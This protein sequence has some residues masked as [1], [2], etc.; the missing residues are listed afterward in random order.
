MTKKISNFEALDQEI[1]DYGLYNLD[2]EI[3][4]WIHTFLDNS[5]TELFRIENNFANINKQF[6]KKYFLDLTD[7]ALDNIK[8]TAIN[9]QLNLLENKIINLSLE[10]EIIKKETNQQ[11]VKREAKNRIKDLKN[12]EKFIAEHRE[13]S[14]IYLNKVRKYDQELNHFQNTV[15]GNAIWINDYAVPTDIDNIKEAKKRKRSLI[16]NNEELQEFNTLLWQIDILQTDQAEKDAL[17]QRLE[18]VQDGSIDP[19]SDPYIFQYYEDYRNIVCTYPYLDE[20]IDYENNSLNNW[21]RNANIVVYQNGRNNNTNNNTNNNSISGNTRHIPKYNTFGEAVRQNW[22]EGWYDH[23]MNQTNITPKQ[24][25]FRKWAATVGGYAAIAIIGFSRVKNVW[26]LI[27]NKDGERTDKKIR[28]KVLWLPILAFWVN[29]ATGRPIRDINGVIKDIRNKFGD[30]NESNYDGNIDDDTDTERLTY[31]HGFPKVAKYFS[32]M[33]YEQMSHYIEKDHGKMKIKYDELIAYHQSAGSSNNIISSLEELKKSD[34]QHNLIHLALTWAGITYDDINDASKKNLKFNDTFW[35]AANRLKALDLFMK[36]NDI[37]GIKTDA[38]SKALL[39]DFIANSTDIRNDLDTLKDKWIFYLNDNIDIN[40]ED[41]NISQ[42][43]IATQNLLG[44]LPIGDI[45]TIIDHSNMNIDLDDLNNT[46]WTININWETMSS[47]ITKFKADYGKYDTSFVNIIKNGL[48]EMWISDSLILTNSAISWTT[49]DDYYKNRKTLEQEKLQREADLIELADEYNYTYDI[50]D[51]NIQS[52]LNTWTP[53]LN[54]L[55]TMT[56]S[57]LSY[58]RKNS[59][60]LKDERDGT[61]TSWFENKITGATNYPALNQAELTALTAI[62]NVIT[63]NEKKANISFTFDTYWQLKLTVF[64]I[65]IDG[66]DLKNKTINGLEKNGSKI[67]F[68][69]IEDL[70]MTASHTTYL[71]KI[72]Q[73]SELDTNQ[74]NPRNID[75]PKRQ[76]KFTWATAI[77]ARLTNYDRYDRDGNLPENLYTL[78]NNK[79]NLRAYADYLNKKRSR[80]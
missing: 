52:Y 6:E 65:R 44:G 5:G 41:I 35:L 10:Y 33:S 59:P 3:N 28:A 22:A 23:L 63:K 50:N 64:G 67:K 79:E 25:E 46:Y 24:R 20:Y 40:A 15:A 13:V 57:P 27:R 7:L 55:E 1:K 4:N 68:T 45:S 58:N 18:G 8:N 12:M 26:K 70:I 76:L 37:V 39:H 19:W 51:T 75:R 36:D 30:K 56:S 2:H 73:N 34:D 48:N 32:G 49:L 69:S 43:R 31:Y 66:L 14:E 53:N 72:S 21:G 16:K 29:A 9:K 54:A 11:E 42:Q 71:I 62:F 78:Q 47:K 60:H 80:K 38:T 74:D 77:V 61:D 17:R